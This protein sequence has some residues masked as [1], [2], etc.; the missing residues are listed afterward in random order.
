[1]SATEDEPLL[2]IHILGDDCPF[3]SGNHLHV[4]WLKF[5]RPEKKFSSI[6]DLKARIA[7]DCEDAA[8][9]AAELTAR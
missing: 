8:R 3:D 2:E 7:I 4:D 6:Q 5:L 1:V 9:I